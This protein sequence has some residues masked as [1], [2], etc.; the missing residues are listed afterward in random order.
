MNMWKFVKILIVSGLMLA[1]IS[2]G[3]LIA[4]GIVAATAI[5]WKAIDEA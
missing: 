5:L 1:A 2:E 3:D 4:L